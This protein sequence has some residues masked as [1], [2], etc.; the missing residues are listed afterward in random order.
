MADTDQNI[1]PAPDSGV[2]D[3]G[4]RDSGVQDNG[5]QLAASVNGDESAAHASCSEV[6]WIF[7]EISPPTHIPP[8]DTAGGRQLGDDADH[9]LAASVTSET[10]SNL[11]HA[12]DQLTTTTD[13][14]DVPVF[15]FHSP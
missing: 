12:L 2:Q 3:T 11:D 7:G 5:L 8:V 9:V 4:A 1:S 6:V 14:F 15:D 13:L 10:P